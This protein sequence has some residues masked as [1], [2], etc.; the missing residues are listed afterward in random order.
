M[1]TALTAQFEELGV[2]RE[3]IHF[4]DFR[5]RRVGVRRSWAARTPP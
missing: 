1:I 3:R 2:P 5:L 4:E